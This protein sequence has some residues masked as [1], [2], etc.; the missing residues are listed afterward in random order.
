MIDDD[1]AFDGDSEPNWEG[2]CE[3]CGSSP[4]HPLTGMC[5]HCT[6]GEADTMGGNW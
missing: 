6:F 5:G 3:V 1:D 2:K 4:T